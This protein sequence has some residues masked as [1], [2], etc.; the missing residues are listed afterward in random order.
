MN[1]SS[2]YIHYVRGFIFSSVRPRGEGDR[3]GRGIAPH[4]S[5]WRRACKSYVKFEDEKYIFEVASGYITLCLVVQVT[6]VSL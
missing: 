1:I 4:A 6:S 5:F 3:E 2:S